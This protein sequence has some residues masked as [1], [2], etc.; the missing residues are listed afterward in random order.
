MSSLAITVMVT[1][2]KGG[3]W[4][5]GQTRYP[6][7]PVATRGSQNYSSQISVVDR[8]SVGAPNLPSAWPNP[9]SSCPQLPLNSRPF[10][11]I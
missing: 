5:T 3:G 4:K 9:H 2:C 1:P 10:S 8:G 11:L 7:I 6:S